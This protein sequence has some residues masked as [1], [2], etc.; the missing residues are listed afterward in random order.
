[1]SKVKANATTTTKTTTVAAPVIPVVRQNKLTEMN[2]FDVNNIIFSDKVLVPIP[3]GTPNMTYGRVNISYKNR[4]GTVGD[5]LLKTP[6]NLYSFGVSANKDF[7]NPENKEGKGFTLTLSMW[8]REG[9]TPEQKQ[10]TDKATQILSRVKSHLL[11]NMKALGLDIVDSDLRKMDIFYWKKENGQVVEGKG[12]TM[13]PKI[14]QSRKPN[15]STGQ[16]EV[17]TFSKFLD[18]NF[19]PIDDPTRTLLGV[20]GNATAIIKF[21]SIYI[22]SKISIQF[23]LFEAQFTRRESTMTSFLRPASLGLLSSSSVPTNSNSGVVATTPAADD[24]EDDT[25]SINGDEDE[26][27][28][29]EQPVAA[30]VKPKKLTT[31]KPKK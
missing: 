13:Y 18:E 12:P 31:V 6:A 27:V 11:Q 5:L 4:D 8:N 23:K 3:G 15:K 26:P 22:G 10:W 19:Q 1:M 28:V 16:I 14:W 30:P 21:E 25:G 7:S 29:A 2:D 9:P 17:K 24:V 20:G